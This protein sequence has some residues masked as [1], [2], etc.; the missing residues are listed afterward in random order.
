MVMMA[1]IPF[2]VPFWQLALS[3]A[4]L[5]VGIV[6]VIWFAAKVYRVGILMYGKKP[7]I[8]ELIRWTRYK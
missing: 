8:A 4:L 1:R 6:F 2:G 5:Y 3:I 7:T